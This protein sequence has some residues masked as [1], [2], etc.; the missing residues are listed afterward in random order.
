[1]CNTD[2]ISVLVQKI[3]TTY[4][5]SC[6]AKTAA[7]NSD[8]VTASSGNPVRVQRQRMVDM[9]LVCMQI[10]THY[11]DFQNFHLKEEPSTV[12][13]FEIIEGLRIQIFSTLAKDLLAYL[14][15]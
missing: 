14:K 4:L 13:E 3:A 2:C 7:V 1:M 5:V 8:R 15:N 10:Y 11:G 12:E 6:Q 9:T